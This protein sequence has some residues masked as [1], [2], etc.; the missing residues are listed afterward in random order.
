MGIT[1]EA[2]K[3]LELINS[4]LQAEGMVRLGQTKPS[5]IIYE[6]DIRTIQNC[7]A[8]IKDYAH[9][10][11]LQLTRMQGFMDMLTELG[12]IEDEC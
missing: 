7:L 8:D 11:E 6:E 3:A 10:A 1:T 2:N 9:K 12:K 4:A 5:K